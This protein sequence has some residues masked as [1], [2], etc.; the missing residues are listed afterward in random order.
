M[1]TIYS[2]IKNNCTPP[3]GRR[4]QRTSSVRLIIS[5]KTVHLGAGDSKKAPLW[6]QAVD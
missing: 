1:A 4:N 5:R 2:F 3:V 6:R